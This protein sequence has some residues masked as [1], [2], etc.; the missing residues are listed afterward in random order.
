MHL[1]PMD[2]NYGFDGNGRIS[3]IRKQMEW[4]GVDGCVYVLGAEQ[5][6]FELNQ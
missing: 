3:K 4:S 1:G 2:V 5:S 6:T